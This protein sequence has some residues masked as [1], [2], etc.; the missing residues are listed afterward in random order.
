MEGVGFGVYSFLELIPEKERDIMVHAVHHVSTEDLLID[1]QGK[2]R[3]G[4]TSF[5]QMQPRIFAARHSRLRLCH[6]Q[7]RHLFAAPTAKLIVSWS[8]Q[9]PAEKRDSDS[10]EV[11]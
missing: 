11:L 2:K 6:Y 3:P 9:P 7:I 1:L 10:A 8:C 5:L 4:A